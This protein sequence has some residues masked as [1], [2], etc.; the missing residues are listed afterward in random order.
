[1]EIHYKDGERIT[2]HTLSGTVSQQCP[3][4]DI[5]LLELVR[6]AKNVMESAGSVG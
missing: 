4:R 2:L 1:M 5:I 6:G 3:K